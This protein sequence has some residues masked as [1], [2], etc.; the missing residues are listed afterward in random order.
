MARLAIDGVVMS[1]MKLFAGQDTSSFRLLRRFGRDEHGGYTIV[2]AIALPTLIGFAGLGA[3][4]GLWLR[5]HQTAQA[6]S[7]AAAVA[8]ATAYYRQGNAADINLQARAVSATYKLIHGAGGVSVTVA[9]PPTSGSQMANNNAI[10]VRIRQPQNRL[11]SAFFGNGAVNVATRSVATVNA[12]GAACVLALNG[13]AAGATTV[14]G[15]ADIVLNSCSMFTNSSN[16]SAMRVVGNATVSAVSVGAVGGISGENRISTTQGITSGQ[17]PLN[18]PYENKT[19]PA[20]SGC[21]AN[22]KTA[23]NSETLS[24]GVYCGGLK[25]NAGANV[26]LSPG[27]YIMDKGS[28]QVNGN[29]TLSG[30]GV[31]IIYTSSTGSNYANATINGG[32][33]VNLTAPTTGPTAGL[34]MMG[35]RNMPQGTAF[36]F[37]GGST[38]NFEGAVYLPK[39]DMKYAGGSTGPGG[40][41]QVIGDTITF[42]GNANVAVNCSNTAVSSIGSATAMLV[43]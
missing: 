27:V 3:D 21:D 11:Y 15:T 8:A 34:V 20:F 24:P 41:T 29:A 23:K 37:N 40:C 7:D 36:T 28:L 9:R 1:L 18:D 38:Q 42:T 14:Q 31:T 22:N 2:A 19:I 30:T 17:S 32:A 5:S 10:E 35:D 12:T 26:T 39:A 6:A 25:L 16:A 13:I 33:V 43:E 4:T